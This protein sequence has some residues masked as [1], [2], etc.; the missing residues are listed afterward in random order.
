MYKSIDTP[1]GNSPAASEQGI[2]TS[3]MFPAPAVGGEGNLHFLIHLEM[4]NSHRNDLIAILVDTLVA[5][6]HRVTVSC[7]PVIAFRFSDSGAVQVHDNRRR[8][9][10][11]FGGKVLYDLRLLEMYCGDRPGDLAQ[12]NEKRRKVFGELVRE[13]NPDWVILW[14]GNFHYQE[15]TRAALRD[16]GMETRTLFAEV[17]WFPQKEHLYLDTKGVNAFSTIR[18][19]A[20]PPLLPHQ[21]V[22]LGLWRD[23]FTMQRLGDNPPP[24]VPGRV[25]VPLQVDTDTSIARSSPFK[26]MAAFIT[27]LEEWIPHDREVVLK[28][29]PKATYDYVPSSK[30]LNFRIV[31]GGTVEGMLTSADT[32][33]GINSTVLLEAVALGKRVVAFGEGL[34]T[35]TGSVVEAIPDDDAQARLCDDTCQAARDSF[36]YHLVFEQQISVAALKRRDFAHLASRAPFNNMARFTSKEFGARIFTINAEEGKSMIKIGKSKVAKTACLDVERGGQITIGDD[37]E[38]RH[39]AVLEVSGRYNGSIE[40]GNHCVIGIGNWLQGSGL[41]KIGNDVIIG[42]YVAIVS[43]NHQYEDVNT[44]VA[45]Q[46]LTTGEIVIE[47]D[48]WIGAHVT[49]AQNVRIGAHSI[50]GANSFV[51]KNVPPYSIVAGAPAKVIKS[52]K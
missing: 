46:P 3:T 27:F 2:E 20:Y 32:V 43:T 30:R 19:E 12:T 22:R 17:A 6:G 33:V 49:I 52:R 7:E 9:H 51:N 15:G 1:V 24:L 45:Q 13:A 26:T 42:P 50:I 41:I 44:P 23:R 25:F 35:G 29:H 4:A 28:L 5:G 47:D 37:C 40:I 34:F 48:V 39:H 38:I 11:A 14:S 18:G 21:K 36:L 31:A 16:A 10:A 8:I